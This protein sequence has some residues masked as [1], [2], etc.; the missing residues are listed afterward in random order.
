MIAVPIRSYPP[1]PA[2]LAGA[3]VVV[4]GLANLTKAM[5]DPAGS[6]EAANGRLPAVE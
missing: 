4:D 1:D 6:R 2:E 5:I 3:D